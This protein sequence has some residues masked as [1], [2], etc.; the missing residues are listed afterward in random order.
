MKIF[1]KLYF[2]LPLIYILIS[3][4]TILNI[5]IT[6]VNDYTEIDT[7]KVYY[8]YI[9]TFNHSIHFMSLFGFYF[10][11]YIIALPLNFL[12]SLVGVEYLLGFLN[13]LAYMPITRIIIFS[14]FWFLIGLLID[15]IIN[16]F[17]KNNA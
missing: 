10:F 17:K 11:Y 8:P 4:P 2:W 6:A 12:F 9:N 16:K 7:D 3:L 15:K 14:I 5:L 13:M 1:K